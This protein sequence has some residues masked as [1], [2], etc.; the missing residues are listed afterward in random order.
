MADTNTLDATIPRYSGQAY[1]IKILDIVNRY[2]LRG[3]ATFIAS[4]PYT[5]RLM[6]DKDQNYRYGIVYLDSLKT[7]ILIGLQ[8]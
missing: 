2:G 6:A 1:C 4:V 5:L 8:Y 3:N 7:L